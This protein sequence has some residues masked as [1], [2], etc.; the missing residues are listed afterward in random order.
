MIGA[1]ALKWPKPAGCREEGSARRLRSAV[2]VTFTALS[3]LR[4]QREAL[5]HQ[6]L[7]DLPQPL[8]ALWVE[9]VRLDAVEGVGSVVHRGHV[10]VLEIEATAPFEL[11]RGSGEHRGRGP[12]LDGLELHPAGASL[13]ELHVLRLQVSGELGHDAARM[14]GIGVHAASRETSL[15]ADREE[16]VGCLRLAVREPLVVRSAFELD[17][18]EDDRRHVMAARA[19]RSHATRRTLTQSRGEQT[20]HDEVAEVVRAE[21][22]LEAVR[23]L[24]RWACHDAGIVDEDVKSRVARQE[25]LREGPNLLQRAKLELL[26]LDVLVPRRGANPRRNGLAFRHVSGGEN[27]MGTSLGQDARRLL[28]Q[29][30]RPAGDERQLA[31]Q[32]DAFCDLARGGLGAEPRRVTHGDPPLLRVS[33]LPARRR[34]RA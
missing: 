6:V 7:R 21:L 33:R 14:Q 20:G 19:D 10:T 9:S 23:R 25:A 8:G 16:N 24:R 12:G 15:E 27:H 26:D 30:A 34:C 5:A 32:V 3:R 1:Q 28:S 31:A 13:E 11:R 4:A 2:Y 18:I 17:V 29:S 22:Q